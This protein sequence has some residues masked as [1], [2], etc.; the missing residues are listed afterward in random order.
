VHFPYVRSWPETDLHE[1]LINVCFLGD[2]VAKL[3]N[4]GPAKFRD[5]PVE[6]GFRRS[7]AL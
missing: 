7:D 1:R 6:T 4:E 3:K 2:C 5:L